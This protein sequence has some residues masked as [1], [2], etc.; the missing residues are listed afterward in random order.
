MAPEESTMATVTRALT[1]EDLLDTPDDRQRYE[2]IGGK[3]VVTPMPVPIHQQVC[4]R[5]GN[6]F[7]N[8]VTMH[9]LG[10]VYT[11]SPD[12]RLTP[13]D[14][15]VPDIIYVS[16]ARR[17]IVRRNL[18]DGAPDLIVE[19][20]SPRTRVRDRTE[21]AALYAAHGV[22]ESWLVDPQDRTIAVHLTDGDALVAGAGETARSRILPGFEVDVSALFA[23]LW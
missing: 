8:F 21:K 6:W 14:I 11:A 15:V 9:D 4:S 22:R 7:F 12:V 2:I 17:N 20:L 3:L 10:H 13:H 1:Y 23:D 5:L 19:V 16:H 18:I